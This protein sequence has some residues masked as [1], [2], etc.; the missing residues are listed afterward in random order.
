M[1]TSLSWIKAYV[2][3]LDVTAQEYTDAMTLSGSKVEG[4][5]ALDADLDKI[6]VGQIQKIERHPDADKLVVCQVDVGTGELVQIVTGAPNVKEGQKVPV[7]L[8]GGRVAG[9]HDGKK[10]PGGIK[11]KK[12][13]LRGVASA[14]M[15]CSIEELGSSREMYPEAPEEGIYIFGEDAVVGESAVKALGLNDVVF[16]YEITSNRVDCFGVLGLAREAAATFGKEFKPP[17]VAET[18]NDEDVNDYIKVT[19][20]DADLCPRYCARVVKNIKIAP[21]PQWMQ[22]RLASQGIRP[23]NNIVDITNYVMEE[24]GQ[25]MHA[26]DLETI[27]SREIIVRRAG[28]DEAFV[29]LDGQ[30]RRM[31]DSVLMICDGEKAVGIAGI[32][33]GENSMI[34]DSVQTMLFEA[35]CF[36]GTNIRLSSKKIGLRTDASGKFEKGLDPNN[37]QNAINRACQLIEELGAG[38]VV[39]G[40][41]DVYGK[42]K[43]GRKILF[44]AGKVNRL[45][46][47][48]IDKETMVGYFEKLGLSYDWEKEEVDVPSWRQDLECLADLAEEVA[49]FYGYDNIPTTLPTGEATTGKLSFKLRVEA[50]AR[51]IAEFCGFSQGMTYSFESPKVFDKLLLPKDS[52]L[53]RA[54]VISNPLGEDFSIMRTV[55]LHGMLTSLSTNYNRRNKNVRLYELGNIYLPKQVPV[56]E[57]PDERMQFTLGMYGDGDFYT[58]KGVIEEFFSKAGLSGKEIYDPHAG[59]PFLHPGRQANVIYDGEVV[60]YLGEVHPQVADNYSIKERVYVAVIDMPKI[61]EL[62]TFDRKYEGIARFPAVSR[63]ISMVMP[64]DILVGEVEKVFDTKGGSYLEHYELFDIYEGS[65][66]KAGF[67][68]VAY[69]LTFR[70][71]DKTLEETDYMPAMERILKALEGMGIELRK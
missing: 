67:K 38:E 51:D 68:S 12:G 41:V 2:P 30:E 69:S 31:D 18:G 23:I 43:E 50:V 10:T 5:E 62:A 37:A 39:G 8:D 53:R 7:V 60:G 40:M 35:A 3:D 49:R 71:K 42:R 55:S 21:S 27:A 22:R 15:M 24:Y 13:K 6:V 59:K 14:G 9:G 34:T 47:T 58:M 29:T 26:Y 63:D 66:I 32:M 20:Q 25:P 46:G 19:V 4:F 33:G 65:Q 54:V 61:V 70:A 56:T 16:E 52:A 1:N 11:I 17:V 45:L 36:D 64:K 57:L 28:K 48:E 44:D